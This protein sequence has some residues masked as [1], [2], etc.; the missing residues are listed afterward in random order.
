MTKL[1]INPD[2]RQ[3]NWERLTELFETVGW[4]YRPA[5]DI[6]KAFRQSSYCCFIYEGEKIVG[7]GRTVD[8]GKYYALLVDVVI[9]PDHEGKGLGTL[10]VN[11]LKDQLESYTFITLSAA[12]GK[13][14]FYEKI[15]WKRQ[16][17][18]FM[19]PVSE[20]QFEEH[21]Q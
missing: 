2:L 11:S 13:H 6:E 17:S 12:P 7:F 19:F 14:G 16:T 15:G 5:A 21:C 10:I 3:I 4:G 18:A 1:K 8:D 9:D 20:K